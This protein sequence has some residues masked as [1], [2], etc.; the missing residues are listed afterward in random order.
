MAQ[1]KSKSILWRVWAC[2]RVL[3]THYKIFVCPFIIHW[4]ESCGYILVWY[5]F[6]VSMPTYFFTYMSLWNHNFCYLI[7]PFVILLI[8]VQ[9]V[10]LLRPG[11]IAIHV[12][13]AEQKWLKLVCNIYAKIEVNSLF[14]A[15]SDLNLK[16][17]GEH[18]YVKYDAAFIWNWDRIFRTVI[19][20]VSVVGN[21]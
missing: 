12:I 1:L 7:I 17:T 4:W 18:L 19:S 11:R 16:Q 2:T 3:N 14:C 13:Q 8:F 9:F 6:I 21:V 10:R 5:I 15:Y 20:L